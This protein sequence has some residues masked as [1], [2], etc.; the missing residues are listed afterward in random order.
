[1]PSEEWADAGPV[2][3]AGAASLRLGELLH[4]ASFDL[5]E[6][7]SAVEIMEPRMDVGMDASGCRSLEE[8]LAAGAAKANPSAIEVLQLAEGLLVRHR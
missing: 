8:A 6:A 4:S 1:M 2:L 3:D 5:Y 7:M